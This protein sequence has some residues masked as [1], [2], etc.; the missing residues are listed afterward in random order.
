MERI[1]FDPLFRWLVEI[2]IDDAASGSGADDGP[3]A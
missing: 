3:H 1:E 2:G